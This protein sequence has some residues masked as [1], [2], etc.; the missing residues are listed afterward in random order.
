MRAKLSENEIRIYDNKGKYISN[1]GNTYSI[2]DYIIMKDS[3]SKTDK[4]K[5]ENPQFFN[6][7]SG[8]I[9][10]WCKDGRVVCVAKKKA[11]SVGLPDKRQ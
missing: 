9:C 3:K 2:G 10:Y 5:C 7:T 1:E 11:S 4:L 8:N 6:E